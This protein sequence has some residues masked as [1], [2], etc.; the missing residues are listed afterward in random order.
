MVFVL[1]MAT[2]LV[3]APAFAE[4]GA[5]SAASDEPAAVEQLGESSTSSLRNVYDRFCQVAWP[6]LSIDRDALFKR[7][8][9]WV[10][11]ENVNF[12]SANEDGSLSEWQTDW[13][14]SHDWSDY[15]IAIANLEP[16]DVVTVNGKTILV[17]GRQLW[18]SG[19]INWD[20]YDQIGWD[21]VVFQTCLGDESVWIA[22]GVPVYPT[23]E[24]LASKE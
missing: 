21:K 13:F 1:S 12:D 11:V 15:G 7:H 2:T 23:P 3:P 16:G 6:I 8:Y 22:Y 10:A 18:P 9:E 14:I 17:L 20:I 4:D 24:F 19:S 5:P